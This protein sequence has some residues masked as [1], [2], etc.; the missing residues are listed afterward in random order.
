MILRQL[1]ANQPFWAITAP[2]VAGGLLL[3]ML[4]APTMVS[5]DRHYP[6]DYFA[7]Q[8]NNIPGGTLIAVVSL[9][10]LGALLSS[11]VFNRNEFHSSP[12]YVP[13]FLYALTASLFSLVSVNIPLLAANLFLLFGSAYLLDV[14]RQARVL[15]EYFRA[16]FW[17]GCAALT[18]PPYLS[19][20]LGLFLCIVFTRALHLREVGVA[21]MAFATPFILWLSW[22]FWFREW[23]YL[24]LFYKV[25][26]F[27]QITF[28]NTFDKWE[29]FFISATGIALLL[30]VPRFFL[31][32]DR[33]SNK[34][35]SVRSTFIT[36]SLAVF[37]ALGTGYL[38]SGFWMPEIVIVP[39]TFVGGYWFT[40]YRF[41]LFAPI[42]FYAW[43]ALGV[44]LTLSAYHFLQ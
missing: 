42:V 1:S 8:L 29:L 21:F 23:D 20:A 3:P 35:R 13:V 24:F 15:D 10:V 37:L 43:L 28:S 33:S 9:I 2:L 6:I 31:L 16:G 30:A 44:L 40:N 14:F 38:F 4:G 22:K 27:D 5:P 32:G 41:S 34:A 18:F 36:L 39:F 11:W 25:I 7:L 17:L 26:T 19:L 12:T